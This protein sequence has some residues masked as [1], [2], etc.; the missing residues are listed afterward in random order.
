M[1]EIATFHAIYVLRFWLN[2]KLNTRQRIFWRFCSCWFRNI[3][4]STSR[5]CVRVWSVS[6]T[7]HHDFIWEV[8]FWE[9]LKKYIIC[10]F[11]AT[12]YSQCFTSKSNQNRFRCEYSST[13]FLRRHLNFD[14]SRFHF[15]RFASSIFFRQEII[16]VAL[17]NQIFAK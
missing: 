4:F 16:L 7:N 5:A 8:L 11:N 13:K 10:S 3:F 12:N 14:D 9:I 6:H 1:R 2:D 15:F 17:M